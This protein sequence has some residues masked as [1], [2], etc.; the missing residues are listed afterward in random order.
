MYNK[1]RISL[2]LL[3]FIN[4][5]MVITKFRKKDLDQ[6]Q[7]HANLWFSHFSKGK[8]QLQAEDLFSNTVYFAKPSWHSWE[9]RRNNLW[10]RTKCLGWNSNLNTWYCHVVLSCFCW[11]GSSFS[12]FFGSDLKTDLESPCEWFQ[13]FKCLIVVHHQQSDLNLIHVLG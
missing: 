6:A 12:G 10:Q 4:L 13:P 3:R 2:G 5:K 9:K 8:N 7:R 11:S 1:Y